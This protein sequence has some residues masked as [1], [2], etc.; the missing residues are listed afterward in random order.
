MAKTVITTDGWKETNRWRQTA[1]ITVTVQG[2]Q[3][4]HI[5]DGLAALDIAYKKAKNLLMRYGREKA[6]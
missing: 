3:E 1:E 4:H 6:K 2:D 5:N